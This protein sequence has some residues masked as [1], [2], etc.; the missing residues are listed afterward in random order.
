MVFN[1]INELVPTEHILSATDNSDELMS[2]VKVKFKNGRSLSVIRGR[3]SYGGP[4]GLFE[5][6]PSHPEVFDDEDLGDE[7]LG[8]LT[9]ERVNYY[10]KKIGEC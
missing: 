5:I 6:M 1:M 7:V 2:R 4:Q 3:Y 8:Y 10:I 9:I